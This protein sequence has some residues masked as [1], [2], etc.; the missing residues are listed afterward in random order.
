[1]GM[2]SVSVAKPTGTRVVLERTPTRFDVTIPPAGLNMSTGFTGAFALAWNAF[3]AVW[4]VGAIGSGGLLFALFS[5]PF[6]F[7]GAQI[8]RQ[9]LVGAL[10]R[11]RLAFG[12]SRFR[13][14]QELALLS[15]DGQPGFGGP[16]E[17]VVEGDTAQLL[18]ARVV[19]TVV[20]NGEPQTAIEIINGA[21]TA[22]FG[23]GLGLAEQQWLVCEVNEQLASMRGAPVDYA[24]FPLAGVPETVYDA[25]A[26]TDVSDPYNNPDR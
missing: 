14:A 26:R 9:A 15:G 25:N 7:A 8:G 10:M 20:V 17:G 22:R 23:E 24:A 16:G 4:T 1:M 5:L 12:P 2:G 18:G 13:L 11:E 21:Q 19:T 6:W 3:V